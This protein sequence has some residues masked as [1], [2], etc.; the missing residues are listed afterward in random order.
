MRHYLQ[1]DS[2][3]WRKEQWEKEQF[4]YLIVRGYFFGW[5]PQPQ[6]HHLALDAN[7]QHHQPQG[8]IFGPDRVAQLNQYIQDHPEEE[9][10]LRLI[11]DSPIRVWQATQCQRVTFGS[12]RQPTSSRRPTPRGVSTTL[13]IETETI[14][15]RKGDIGGGKGDI[16]NC[17]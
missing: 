16:V 6:G 13:S 5:K 14:G 7:R 15:R 17:L 2:Y 11:A 10:K 4:R 1:E 8:H 3:N 9:L 12:G